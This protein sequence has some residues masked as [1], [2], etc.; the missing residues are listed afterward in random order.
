MRIRS[1]V[2]LLLL[3]AG[4]ATLDPAEQAGYDAL[5]VQHV[6]QIAE[7]VR[8]YAA[9]AGRFPLQDQITNQA[10]QVLMTRGPLQKWVREQVAVMPMQTLD[11]GVLEKDLETV[12]G[13]DITLPLDPQEDGRYWNNFYIYLVTREWTCVAGHLFSP[14]PGTRNINDRY[15][16]YEI[17]YTV[18][19]IPGWQRTG[20]RK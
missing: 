1:I 13:P 20:R 18:E 3:S 5:R 10:I 12:L 6:D 8:D 14:A 7:L 2:A 17:C 9:R 11:T 4:C 19:D 15:H 16:K